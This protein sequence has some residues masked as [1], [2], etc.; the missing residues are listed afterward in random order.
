[1]FVVDI[2]KDEVLFEQHIPVFSVF[3]DKYRDAII[4]EIGSPSPS[5]TIIFPV[6]H[7]GAT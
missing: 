7:L 2:A 6:S 5:K 1:M 4:D 3:T